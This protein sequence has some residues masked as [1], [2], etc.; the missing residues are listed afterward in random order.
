[1]VFGINTPHSSANPYAVTRKSSL[2]DVATSTREARFSDKPRSRSLE[3]SPLPSRSASSST[4]GRQGPLPEKFGKKSVDSYFETP[5]PAISVGVEGFPEALPRKKALLRSHTFPSGV[6]GN[7]IQLVS[8]N[9]F[10]DIADSMIRS[11]SDLI[12]CAKTSRTIEGM[13]TDKKQVIIDGAFECNIVGITG[14]ENVCGLHLWPKS[15]NAGTV[16]GLDETIEAAKQRIVKKKHSV[17]AFHAGGLKDLKESS[18]LSE[19]IQL[20]MR[21]ANIK[22][23]STIWGKQ[24]PPELSECDGMANGRLILGASS[25]VHVRDKKTW[26]FHSEDEGGDVLTYQ[27]LRERFSVVDIAVGDCVVAQDGFFLSVPTEDSQDT[28]PTKMP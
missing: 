5:D 11:E 24:T 9:E 19:K 2:P 15:E 8:K 13:V 26:F 17:R 18:Q 14:G 3:L 21:A 27:R 6:G 22:N 12:Y 4:C 23:I 1:M 28:K 10:N 16:D 7:I 20:S 25:A